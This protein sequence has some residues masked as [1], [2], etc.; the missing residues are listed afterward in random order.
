MTA[1][2]WQI[3]IIISS[4][5]AQLIAPSIAALVASRRN[6]PKP[7]PE[8]NQPKKRIQRIGARLMR[9]FQSL[10]WIV[11]WPL[12]FISYIIYILLGE[13]RKTA[14]ITRGDV[15]LISVSV[16][17]IWYLLLNMTVAMMQQSM[18]SLGESILTQ[19][20]T[21]STLNDTIKL[22]DETVDLKIKTF[23]LPKPSPAD[24]DKPPPGTLRKMLNAINKVFRKSN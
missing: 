15:L 11:G 14:P 4:F 21:I 12:V 18:I 23:T 22:L 7:T 5:I 10:W 19:S 1:N 16:T 9:F 8:L 13:L 3:L 2:H 6:Q 20:A 17:V 24:P